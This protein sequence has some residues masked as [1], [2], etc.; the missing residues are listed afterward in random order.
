MSNKYAPIIYSGFHTETAEEDIRRYV[1]F[2]AGHGYSGIC[3]EGKSRIPVDDVPAWAEHFRTLVKKTIEY[4]RTRDIDIWLV[5]DWGYPSGTAAGLIIA[6]NEDFRSKNLHLYADMM[7]DHDEEIIVTVNRKHFISAAVWEVGRFGDFAAP[8]SGFEPLYPS[9]DGVISYKNNGTAKR[10][11][12]VTWEYNSSSTHGI[13]PD[14][15]KN[16]NFGTID[17]LSAPAVECFITKMYEPYY[18]HFGEYFG[19][20]FSGFFYD[21]P[22]LSYPYPYTE[23]IFKEFACNKGYDIVPLLPKLLA[24]KRPLSAAVDYREVAGDRMARVFIARMNEWCRSH[25]VI[26]VGHQDIDHSLRGLSTLSGDFFKNSKA[27]DAPGIDYIW[28][29]INQERFCDYPRFAGS[30][31]HL[32]AKQ[33]AMS[34]SFAV[35]GR[36]L[37]TDLQRWALEHQMI[38]GIDLFYNMY[39]EPEFKVAAESSILSPANKQN[40]IFGR[41]VNER[42]AE[43]NR[44]LN[45]TVPAAE[46]G[47]YIPMDRIFTDML[48]SGHPWQ[49][50]REPDMAERINEIARAVCYASCDYEYLWRDSILD[51]DIE[52]GAFITPLGQKIT[53]V[54]AAALTDF[55]DSEKERLKLFLSGGGR[56]LSIGGKIRGFERE[57]VIMTKY[58]QE[59][60]HGMVTMISDTMLLKQALRLQG[61]APVQSEGRISLAVRRSVNGNI[62]ALLNEASH[63]TNAILHIG[64][65]ISEYDFSL[66]RFVRTKPTTLLFE[67]GELRIFKTA[68]DGEESGSSYE[69]MISTM[70]KAVIGDF[71]MTAP[72]GRKIPV[73]QGINDWR[74]HISPDYSGIVRFQGSF[75]TQ[76]AGNVLI[77]LSCVMYAAIV[78]IDGRK[79]LLPYYPYR[80]YTELE[81]GVH[82]ICVEI[83]NTGVN[84][85][86]GTPELDIKEHNPRAAFFERDRFRLISGMPGPITVYET[87][88]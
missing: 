15:K 5:N 71:I 20:G 57:S 42:A 9:S 87:E 47:I 64:G 83:M 50:S 53:I 59:L 63:K 76:A 11:T 88:S 52:N 85:L 70:R 17:L 33:H 23:G 78:Y 34:E 22:Y 55:S 72:D 77:D 3:I 38:R 13:F 27:S 46:I 60:P 36:A 62:Y 43:V 56:I 84:A 4:A 40:I 7:I 67:P 1:D 26:Q 12:I 39:A 65:S 25:N 80:I 61:I 29:Q 54:I 69:E 24:E 51:M 75:Q 30:A 73:G 68:A 45:S 74:S 81:A 10:L 41:A 79:F 14:D 31:K 2:C 37:P 28:E 19:N 21:E 49:V 66:H 6:E 18:E 44:L 16:P 32:Y 48:L 8:E 58:S 82:T 86:I 35:A